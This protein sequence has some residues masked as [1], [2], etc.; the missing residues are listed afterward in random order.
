MEGRQAAQSRPA[1]RSRVQ[2]AIGEETEGSVA[3]GVATG[4]ARERRKE[5]AREKK[6]RRARWLVGWCDE[7]GKGQKLKAKGR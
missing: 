2:P 4:G 6:S 7:C 3:G 1:R 5:G